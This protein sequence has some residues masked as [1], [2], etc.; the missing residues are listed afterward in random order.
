MSNPHGVLTKWN[1]KATLA[2]ADYNYNASNFDSAPADD[3]GRDAQVVFETVGSAGDETDYGKL[4]VSVK[5]N[6]NDAAENDTMVIANG[7]TTFGC[8]LHVDDSSTGNSTSTGC[9]V[10]D[11]DVGLSLIH[12]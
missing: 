1:S 10:F 8:K 5:N 9:A 7:T 2:L 6:A 3:R 4:T 12:I 11:G